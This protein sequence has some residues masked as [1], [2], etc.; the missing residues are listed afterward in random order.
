M[1]FHP[2]QTT[3][4][5]ELVVT[6]LAIDRGTPPQTSSITLTLVLRDINDFPPVFSNASYK[7]VAISN[8]PIGTSLIQ[9]EATD[10]DRFDNMI[11]YSIIAAGNM[12]DVRFRI[13]NGGVI[14]NNDVFPELEENEVCHCN[15]IAYRESMWLL[16]YL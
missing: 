15:Y 11:S 9:V 3:P 12:T 13:D 4:S 5:D 16:I 6:V 2:L 10:A 14:Y 7:A 1:Y 8:S